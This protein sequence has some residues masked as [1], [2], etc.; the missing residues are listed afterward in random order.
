M[1]V[2]PPLLLQLL[3]LLAQLLLQLQLL[4]LAPPQPG[5]RQ[6]QLLLLALPLA[7]PALLLQ[8][9]AALLLLH[10]GQLLPLLLEV[11]LALLL[12]QHVPARGLQPQLLL[13]LLDGGPLHLHA[14]VLLG[15]DCLQGRGGQG[16]IL[17]RGLPFARARPQAGEGKGQGRAPREPPYLKAE[18]QLGQGLDPLDK[19]RR[20]RETLAPC[21][22]R[23]GVC[24]PAPGE[25][26]EPRAYLQLQDRR[27]TGARLCTRPGDL[28][29]ERRQTQRAKDLLIT[30][31]TPAPQ[32]CL[33]S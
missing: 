8:P 27:Q 13:A 23:C 24:M 2:G 29:Q 3:A 10:A 6:V 15:D 22:M 30:D 9:Q 26:D 1:L 20:G 33:V 25:T 11:A 5:R 21:A 31:Q 19:L 4:V 12:Q 17:G 16:L 7:L 14:A 18:E 32:P 28:W